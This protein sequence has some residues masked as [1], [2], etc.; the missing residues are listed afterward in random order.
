MKKQIY[1]ADLTPCDNMDDYKEAAFVP[2]FVTDDTKKVRHQAPYRGS[3]AGYPS[4][5]VYRSQMV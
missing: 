5:M 1:Y 4:W 3:A 2:Q